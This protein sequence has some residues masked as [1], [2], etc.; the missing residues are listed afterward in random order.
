MLFWKPT[1]RQLLGDV[2]LGRE[3]LH[4]GAV[5][6]VADED[7]HRVDVRRPGARAASGSGRADA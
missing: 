7:E 2:E 1:R 6:A 4:V 5:L 3:R